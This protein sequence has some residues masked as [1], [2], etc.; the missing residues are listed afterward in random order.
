MNDTKTTPTGPAR[1]AAERA[2]ARELGLAVPPGIHDARADLARMVITPPTAP[3]PAPRVAPPGVPHRLR[4]PHR[5]T[6]AAALRAAIA[7]R[8]HHIDAGAR[9]QV[10]ALLDA[11]GELAAGATATEP[12]FVSLQQRVMIAAFGPDYL[13]RL[14]AGKVTHTHGHAPGRKS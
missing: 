6:S 3:G 9:E 2:R 14:A 12:E 8:L 11:Y 10:P 1:L 5:P 7:D 13:A 4:T